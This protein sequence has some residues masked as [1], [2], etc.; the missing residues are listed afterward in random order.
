MID[1]L[2]ELESYVRYCFDARTAARVDELALRLHMHPSA[3]SRDFKSRTGSRLARTLKD[4]QLA[5][6]KRL[7]AT[8][9]LPTR[10]VACRSG[11]GTQ[12]TLFRVFR[13]RLGVTPERYRRGAREV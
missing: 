12:N 10:D 7:L 8:T 9:L 13:I 3:L 5:E 6:A 2:A 11:F 1:Y 4:L